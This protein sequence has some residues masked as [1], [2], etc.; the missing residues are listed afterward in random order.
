MDAYAAGVPVELLAERYQIRAGAVRQKLRRE[1]V[2]DPTLNRSSGER[3][4]SW[5]GWTIVGGYVYVKPKPEDLAFCVPNG[6]GYVAEHRLVMGHSLGRPLLAT[7]TVHHKNGI[8]DDN[9]LENLQLRQGNHG[10]GSRSICLDC[11]SHNIGAA[12]L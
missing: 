7:E 10:K 4:P 8:R 9:R 1:G 5:Q 12:D 11:G 3:H 6:G 2:L